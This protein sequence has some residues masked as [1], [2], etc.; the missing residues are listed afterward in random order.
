MRHARRLDGGSRFQSEWASGSYLPSASI[1]PP[2]PA[3][4]QSGRSGVTVSAEQ[5]RFNQRI[6]QQGVKRANRATSR[7][8]KLTTGGAG[9][10]GPAGPAGPTGPGA[11]RIAYSAAVGTPPQTVLDLAGLTVSV[12]CEA[13]GGGE[14]ALVIRP[15]V[16]QATTV[17]GTSSTDTGTD[18]NNPDPPDVSN[19][20]APLAP[21][22]ATLGGPVA[23]D[24]EFA[25]S[26]ADVLFIAPARTI[27]LSLAAVAD[28]A[29]DRCSFN[30]VAVPS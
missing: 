2:E 16:A 7:L 15:S 6:G 18:I 27:S 10:V 12:S 20:E 21:G 8:D 28:G 4:G 22:Q 24:G 26:I 5:L 25:R 23:P 14:T 30:G 29:A 1:T 9:P 19:F 13:G 11:A 17:V 3:A